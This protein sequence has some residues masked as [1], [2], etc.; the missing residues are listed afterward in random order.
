M[1]YIFILG[2]NP[3]LSILELKS[4]LGSF[5]YR[6]VGNAILTDVPQLNKGFITK[7]GGTIAIGEVVNIKKLDTS[8]IKSNKPRYVIWNFSDN[9]KFYEEIREELKSRFREE[10]F[11]ATE[12]RI[13]DFLK[14]QSGQEVRNLSSSKLI[15][16]QYFVFNDR[17][18][19]IIETCDYEKLE[20]QDM[21]KPVRRESLAISPRLAK[22]M[23]NLSKA[24]QD[25][26][27]VD[28]FCGVGVI[29]QEALRLEIKVIGIDKD[30]E[31]IKGILKNLKWGKFQE[32]NYQIINTDSITA[33]IKKSNALVT[34]PSLGQV[35]KYA[36][37]KEI[38]SGIIKEYEKLIIKVLNN[39]KDSVSGR[40]VFTGPFIQT[41]S[42]TGIKRMGCDANKIINSTGLKL[43]SGFPVAEFREN[44]VVGREIFVLEH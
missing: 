6:Q 2:R 26:T 5:S 3:E 33:K 11:K 22:I 41:T 23:I 44:Q 16:E 43:V 28:P 10:G 35:L 36:P 21:E 14:L 34:E 19:R 20:K 40:F 42:K 30:S 39:L 8:Y 32:K 15:D 9:E 25:E 29:A 27:I 13:S 12:K 38:A 1:E 37:N 17:F 18:G 7:L 31:A 24:E 4:R